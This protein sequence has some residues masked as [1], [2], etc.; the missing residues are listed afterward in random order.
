MLW[1]KINTIK[2]VV[3]LN[4]NY[5]SMMI[6]MTISI[7]LFKQYNQIIKDYLWDG[8]KARISLQKL[9]LYNIAF[10]LS[11]LAKQWASYGSH[12]GWT[13]IE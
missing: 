3:S 7:G 10:E 8:K 6:P 12:L 4:F 2:M 13:H 1:G 11:K 5:V 9:E